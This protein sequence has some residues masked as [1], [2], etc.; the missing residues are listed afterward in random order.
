[1]Q[2]SRRTSSWQWKRMNGAA[3]LWHCDVIAQLKFSLKARVYGAFAFAYATAYI[4][5]QDEFPLLPFL[6]PISFL[7]SF[8]LYSAPDIAF[9]LL[10]TLLHPVL[11][12]GSIAWHTQKYH[13]YFNHS[14][15]PLKSPWPPLPHMPWSFY[16]M[17][18][19]SNS[20]HLS[21]GL[22]H[23]HMSSV[24]VMLMRS[25]M[26]PMVGIGST[27]RWRGTIC[28]YQ[29]CKQGYLMIVG[30]VFWGCWWRAWA[31]WLLACL[32]LH[33]SFHHPIFCFVIPS[34][35]PL[36]H[37]SFHHLVFRFVIRSLWGVP[38]PP[39]LLA[40]FPSLP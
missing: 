19:A 11:P 2:L 12:V 21:L 15:I 13:Q 10:P 18:H 22:G 4:F 35:V 38:C 28:F 5:L 29:M 20:Q 26:M 34:F 27:C 16:G 32:S 6:C 8:G 30:W 31:S 17:F 24:Q 1:M 7:I 36:S 23:H 40:L 37:C 33:H 25:W 14:T 9:S 39:R 3:M